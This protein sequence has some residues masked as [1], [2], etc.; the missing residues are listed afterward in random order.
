VLG[1]GDY[2]R[3]CGFANVVI[4]LS[5]GI[6]SALTACLAVDALGP[7]HVLTVAMPTRYSSEHSLTDAAALA[8]ALGVEHRVI[9]IDS[10]LQGYLDLLT[11][12]LEGSSSGATEENLQARIRGAVLMAL[13][14]RLGHLLLTTGNKSELAVGYCTLYGDMCGGLAVISDVPKTFVYRLAESTLTKPPSAELRPNQKDSDSLPPYEILDEI[15]EAYVERH[16]DIDA[17]CRTGIDPAIVV[18]V[19]RRIDTSEY[20][21][22]QAAPGIKITSKAFGMGRR[23]PIAADYRNLI[24]GRVPVG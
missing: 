19:V 8:R 3:K 10:I 9:P 21:R 2:A 6:D 15:I 16:L 20:K 22:R 4:G 11:P 17:I 23:Y 18:D 12:V 1:L 14:N 7:E 5:G 13:S 24:A